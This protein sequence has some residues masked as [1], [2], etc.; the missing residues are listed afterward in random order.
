MDVW[1][2]RTFTRNGNYWHRAGRRGTRQ[3]HRGLFSQPWTLPM[4][5]E[6]FN[7]YGYHNLEEEQIWTTLLTSKTVATP[8]CASA[9]ALPSNHWAKRKGR[10]CT[11]TIRFLRW[12]SYQL[13]TSLEDTD[14]MQTTDRRFYPRLGEP[15]TSRG[16]ETAYFPT[17]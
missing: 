13:Y 6:H 11:H 8:T 5:R 17:I 2:A 4:E 3:E 10:C 14:K 9:A 16:Q 15:I 7:R 1:L 12:V